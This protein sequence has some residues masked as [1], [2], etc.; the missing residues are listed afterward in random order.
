[1]LL[2]LISGER[3]ADRAAGLLEQQGYGVVVSP[4][5]GR[6]KIEPAS[7][8]DGAIAVPGA[9]DLAAGGAARAIAEGESLVEGF[10]PRGR[11]GDGDL[12]R[13]QL[14][15]EVEEDGPR[16]FV[17]AASGCAGSGRRTSR[18]TSGTRAP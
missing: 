16:R 15:V 7:S 11:H 4:V 9:R 2:L 3:E 13:A 8:I 1:M 5:L 14:G 12:G 6:V 10:G 18:W 17:C